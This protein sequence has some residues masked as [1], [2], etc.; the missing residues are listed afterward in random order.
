MAT[1]LSAQG[2]KKSCVVV[3]YL[4]KKT[5][6]V[7]RLSFFFI[8]GLKLMS[9]TVPHYLIEKLIQNVIQQHFFQH[10]VKREAE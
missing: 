6:V 8:V 2:L 3:V 4:R 7:L 9:D 1:L 5:K 10:K